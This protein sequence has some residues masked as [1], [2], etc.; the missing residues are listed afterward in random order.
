MARLRK[1]GNSLGVIIPQ[2]LLKSLNLKETD[3]IE[4]EKRDN[5]II[6]KTKDKKVLKAKD[7][8]KD[9]DKQFKLSVKNEGQPDLLIPDVFEDEEVDF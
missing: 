2:Y 9:W 6:I 7:I 8:R 1:I 3:T 5:S 4:F